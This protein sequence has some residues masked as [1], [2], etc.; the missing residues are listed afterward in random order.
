MEILSKQTYVRQSQQKLRDVA[1][2]VKHLPLP[3]L[4]LQ[5]TQMNREAA[6]RI[7]ET[8]NQAVA[9]AQHNF[10]VSEDQLSLKELLILRGPH[11]KRMRPV[12]RG[13]GHAILK[14]TSHI[15]VRLVTAEGVTATPAHTHDHEHAH[16]HEEVTEQAEAAV[17]AKKVDATPKAAKK[18]VSKKTTTST[19]KKTTQKDE[20]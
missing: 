2:V 14:R 9:N 19:K 10:G 16:D 1:R 13:Q 8:V 20:K 12:S 6:K 4:R 17:E 11:Y 18:A 3:A 7:L 15:V 5:L